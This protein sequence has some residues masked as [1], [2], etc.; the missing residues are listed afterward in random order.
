MMEAQSL[1]RRQ[2]MP[3]GFYLIVGRNRAIATQHETLLEAQRELHR[4]LQ[5][6]PRQPAYIAEII[7]RIYGDTTR[8]ERWI[9]L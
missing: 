7:P 1:D 2:F 5:N 4:F 8:V 3:K 9:V 6:N